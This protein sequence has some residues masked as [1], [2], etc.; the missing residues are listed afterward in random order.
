MIPIGSYFDQW[1]RILKIAAKPQAIRLERLQLL[2]DLGVKVNEM[3][4]NGRTALH[5]VAEAGKMESGEI[6]RIIKLL[7]LNGA[8][9]NARD[10]NDL[11]PLGLL[12]N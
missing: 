6:S 5:I 4:K 8:D 10:E 1:Y 3:G 9:V 12:Q 7:L 11:T 2:T